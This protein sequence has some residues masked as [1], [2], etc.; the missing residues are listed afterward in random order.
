MPSR[1]HQQR[2]NSKRVAQ[3]MESWWRHARRDMQFQFGQE[4]M[5]SDVFEHDILHSEISDGK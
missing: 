1:Y 2:G 3:V 5:K 4:S